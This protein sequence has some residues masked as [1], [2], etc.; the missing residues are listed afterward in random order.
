MTESVKAKYLSEKLRVPINENQILLSH[1]P[2]KSLIQRYKDC[3]ILVLLIIYSVL[4][5]W[6]KRFIKCC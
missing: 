4:G 6:C 5:Y 3:R 1:T 2:Y